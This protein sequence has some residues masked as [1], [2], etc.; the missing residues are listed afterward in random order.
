MKKKSTIL[1]LLMEATFCL[2]MNCCRHDLLSLTSLQGANKTEVTGATLLND[3]TAQVLLS[4]LNLDYPGLE[5]V[6]NNAANPAKAIKALLQYYRSRTAIKHPTIPRPVTLVSATTPSDANVRSA[7]SAL[8]HYLVGSQNLTIYRGVDID[9]RSAVPG[10]NDKEWVWQLNRQYFWTYMAK[11]YV[12][13]RDDKYVAEYA[14][15]LAGWIRDNPVPG[16]ASNALGQAWRS[17]EAG[18]RA[19]S[20]VDEFLMWEDAPSF[21]ESVLTLFMNSLFDHAEFLMRNHQSWGNWAGTENNGLAKICILFPEFKRADAWRDQVSTRLQNELNAIVEKDGCSS[22]LSMDYHSVNIESFSETYT[23]FDINKYED[24]LTSYKPV[25]EKMCDVL[26]AM[27][28]PDGRR[29]NFGDSEAGNTNKASR[30]IQT[31]ITAFSFNRPDWKYLI[32]KGASGTPPSSTAHAFTT[33]GLYSM[34]SNWSP[35]A[36]AFVLKCSSISGSHI[37]K[38]NGT[39]ELYA[40]NRNLMPDA[41]IPSYSAS[42]KAYFP[43]TNVHQTLS[44]NDADIKNA[45]TLIKWLPGSTTG[46]NNDILVVQNKSYDNLTHR[47]AVFFVD[48]KYFVM[49][50][51]AMGPAAGNVAVR[52]RTGPRQTG[53]VDNQNFSAHS[54]YP[55]GWNI[56]IRGLSQNG[57]TLT[58]ETSKMDDFR[59][60]VVP[61]PVFKYTIKKDAGT[62]VVR[63]VTLLAP[64]PMGS[65]IPNISVEM[66]TKPDD[67]TIRIR[68]NDGTGAKEIE[69][70]L[71]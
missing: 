15:Q 42:D 9:W 35:D 24:K 6:K 71:R 45:P 28:L 51:D 17:L 69:C 65:A 7:D 26:M 39:F 58:S 48:K 40:G 57:L 59:S 22:D 38:D 54:N 52:F 53:V 36:T 34:R 46:T 67:S 21:N 19:S 20:W 37:H 13:T 11:T 3:S 63:F 29:A 10:L 70:P 23:L 56:Y 66:L 44:L 25:V 8:L 5:E 62:P 61:C 60:G 16:A 47:R 14:R 68:V 1:L 27:T 64:Y 18:L 4:R 31:A 2:S 12:K 55:D 33:G 43:K 32:T 30:T 49:V 50:D 41:G